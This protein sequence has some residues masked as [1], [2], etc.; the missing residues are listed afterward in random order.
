MN[1]ILTTIFLT[2]GLSGFFTLAPQEGK[3]SAANKDKE[4]QVEQ[5]LRQIESDTLEALV[6]GDINALRRIWA[7]EYSFTPPNGSVVSRED[8]LAL[9][10]SG[11]VKYDSLKSESLQLHIYGDTAVVAGRFSV[12]GRVG[13]HEL[14]GTD[15]FLTVYVKRQGRWQQV[16]S[17]A[18]RVAQ[19]SMR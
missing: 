16:A 5:T 11:S 10:E 14:N 7:D 6:K 13:S 4:S 3:A 2:L 18:S 19:P 17:Q 9:L 1:R 12:R 15:R 8:Y